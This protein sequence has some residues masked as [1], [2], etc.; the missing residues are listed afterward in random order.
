MAVLRA[1]ALEGFLR[2]RELAANGFL[3]YGPDTGKA[4]EAA[5]SI[6]R[7]IAGSLEDGFRVVRLTDDDLAADP[8]RLA[9]E[10]FALAMLGGARAVWVSD[11]GQA[12]ATAAAGLLATPS[13]G[14]VLIAEAGNLRKSTPLRQ[15]FETAEHAYAV[16]CYEDSAEDLASLID[17]AISRAGIRMSPT[18]RTELRIALGDDH[19]LTRSEIDKLFLYVHGRDEITEADVRA[20]MSGRNAPSLDE[21]CDAV[22][23]G[24]LAAADRLIQTLLDGGAAGSRLLSAVAAHV[25]LLRTV[26]AE[27]AAGARLSRALQ[28]ARPPVYGSRQRVIATC[29]RHWPAAGLSAAATTLARA[30]LA[31]REMPALESQIAGR[32]LLALA[33]RAARVAG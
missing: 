1:S 29:L 20:V 13:G 21:L 19:A 25:A 18:A 15:L 8:G 27:M 32:A 24:D 17:V 11:A 23:G 33:R 7:R 16:P 4:H 9:D 22:L 28:S 30:T 5:C 12:F 3:V 10:Y 31:T 26:A 14:N 6:V 2:Q